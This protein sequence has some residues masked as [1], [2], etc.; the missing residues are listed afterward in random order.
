MGNRYDT[1]RLRRNLQK[2]KT[3]QFCKDVWQNK[4]ARVGLFIIGFF[5]LMA[6]FGPI[7]MPFKTTDMGASRD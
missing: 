2:T 4:M 3:K 7:L 6:I 5:V 1:E